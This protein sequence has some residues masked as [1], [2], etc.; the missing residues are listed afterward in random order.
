MRIGIDLGGTKIEAVLLGQNGAIDWR[1]RRDT[2]GGDY[3]ATLDAIATLVAEAD[4]VSGAALPLGIGTP[5]AVSVRSG[6]M[7]NCNSTCLIG[8]PLQQDLEQRLAR[9]VRLAND[10]DCFALS[11]ASDGAAA[12][13]RLVYGCCGCCSTSR[14][15]PD[16]TT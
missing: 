2:P 6:R 7:K 13:S 4:R 15:G 11:E 8:Q 9:P 14:D 16:S 1:Q 12:T 5:G 3:A 10:A